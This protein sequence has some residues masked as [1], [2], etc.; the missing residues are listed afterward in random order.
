MVCVLRLLTGYSC[1]LLRVSP[2]HALSFCLGYVSALFFWTESP[3]RVEHLLRSLS[4]LVFHF[5]L[6][7]NTLCVLATS[8]SEHRNPLAVGN[9]GVALLQHLWISQRLRPH[10]PVF[11]FCEPLFFLPRVLCLPLSLIYLF[12]ISL[13]DSPS[14]CGL[15]LSWS[16]VSRQD[17]QPRYV[18]LGCSP[19]SYFPSSS[20]PRGRHLLHLATIV[21][22][23][24]TS[25]PG[26]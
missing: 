11:S 16:R 22:S 2:M 3:C 21:F 12:G 24:Y 10:L 19:T 1:K 25:R 4:S 5:F 8:Y 26:F 17:S 18:G 15:P 7:Y 14:G 13:C 6:V 9:L 23:L 20:V